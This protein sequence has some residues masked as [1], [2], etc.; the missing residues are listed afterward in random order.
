[1]IHKITAEFSTVDQA[2]RAA[3]RLKREFYGI[4]QADV[5]MPKY[6]DG[7]YDASRIVQPGSPN[8]KL[9]YSVRALYAPVN[10]YDAHYGREPGRRT[11]A[12]LEI[13]MRGGSPGRAAGR[14]RNLGGLAVRTRPVSEAGRG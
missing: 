1:M 11:S 7:F 8:A 6:H 13:C 3:I 5:Y 9:G 2:E 14:L 10:F 4:Q 12:T